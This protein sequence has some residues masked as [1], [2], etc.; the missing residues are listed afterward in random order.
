MNKILFTATLISFNTFFYSC[1][2]NPDPSMT[3][4][5][6]SSLFADDCKTPLVCKLTS[7]EMQER[8]AMVLTLLQKNVLEKK[9]LNNGYAFKFQGSD[10]MIDTLTSFIKTERQCCDFFT[11]N[12]SITN[13]KSF[14]WL[15]LSGPEGTKD[16]IKTEM[17]L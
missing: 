1:K 8:K 15:Q 6:T 11:F 7:E 17:E 5:K 16:F 14:V 4:S 2:N 3:S 10:A 13:E 9:E 12:L